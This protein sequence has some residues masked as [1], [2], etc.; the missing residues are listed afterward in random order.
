MRMRILKAITTTEIDGKIVYNYR[1]LFNGNYQIQS[2]Q[3]G[4]EDKNNTFGKSI[5][6][7]GLLRRVCLT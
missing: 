4:K 7:G 6:G 2:L 5:A 3:N 1:Y